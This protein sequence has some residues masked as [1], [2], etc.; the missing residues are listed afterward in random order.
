MA[1]GIAHD[2]N[3]LLTGILG[4]ASLLT[5]IVE[6]EEREMASNIMLAAERAADLTKQ[7]LAYSGKGSF[8]ID[9]L[10]L[11]ALIQENLTLLR[12]SLAR[13]VTVEL[14]LS[15]EACWIEADRAQMQQV[16]MNL[17]INASEAIGDT[18]G[19]VAVHTAV[20]ERVDSQFSAQTK[21]LVPSGRYVLLQVR[22]NGSGMKPET[23]KKIFDPFFTTKFTGRGLGL[24]AVL[25]IIR[26][27]HGDIEV[28]SERGRGTTFRVLLPASQQ[29]EVPNKQAS[30]VPATHVSGQNVLVVDDEEI[31]WSMT[32][33][34][35][36]SRG[37]RVV[38]ATNGEE[39]LEKLRT[40]ADISVVILDLT[41]PVMT[42]EQVLPLIKENYP[43]IPI[44]LSS[45]FNEAEISHRFAS[46]GLAG[47]LQKPYSAQ[48]VLSK[49]THALQSAA[50][51][52]AMSS[53]G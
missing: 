23:L 15:P 46:A 45:G 2:F 20:I 35:L 4:N 9:I 18:P 34:A 31:V 42:G 27:H 24:A 16:V 49:V 6:G 52:K 47:F 12:A 53:G 41:M 43:K 1:G 14:E 11:N 36:T 10:D 29:V 50:P 37:F 51:G 8:I 26:G 38:V 22:D 17:L 3:N 30:S 32:L 21:A 48:A 5:E 44:I 28:E 40:H 7:M 39:A 19:T 25:G 13:N 33:K